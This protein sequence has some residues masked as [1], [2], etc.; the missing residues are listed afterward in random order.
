MGN[1]SNW[2]PKYCSISKVGLK[3]TEDRGSPYGS[4]VPYYRRFAQVSCQEA[5]NKITD[6]EPITHN[7]NH[8]RRN[9]CR[10]SDRE[11]GGVDHDFD[12]SRRKECV[13]FLR[14]PQLDRRA[15][16]DDDSVLLTIFGHWLFRWNSSCR[17]VSRIS[18]R[19]AG[20]GICSISG[21]KKTDSS[22]SVLSVGFL[23]D[24]F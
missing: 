13:Q 6:K 2:G 4:Y 5:K 21:K 17:C 15:L 8:G 16:A 22:C 14:I 19:L 3:E 11:G 10:K 18:T 9:A 20:E 1:F 23:F 24:T 12:S 7:F